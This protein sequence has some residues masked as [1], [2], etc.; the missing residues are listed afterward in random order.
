MFV[1]VALQHDVLLLGKNVCNC[2]KE[3]FP[4]P[5]LLAVI[6]YKLFCLSHEKRMRYKLKKALI[7]ISCSKDAYAVIT[8]KQFG[9]PR[10]VCTFDEF[11]S[12]MT[13]WASGNPSSSDYLLDLGTQAA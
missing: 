4:N 11:T 9:G 10:T 8:K 2:G 13:S 6:D 7:D 12:Q 5:R 1:E 3:R